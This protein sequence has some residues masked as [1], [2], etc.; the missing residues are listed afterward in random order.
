MIEKNIRI[1]KGV[2]CKTDNQWFVEEY[3]SLFSHKIF[4]FERYPISN[5]LNVLKVGD[6][7]NFKLI[8]KFGVESAE[9]V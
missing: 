6:V 4:H 7:V 2:I 1:L 8:N 3:K 5:E 9:L